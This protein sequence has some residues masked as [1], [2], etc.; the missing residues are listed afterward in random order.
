MLNYIYVLLTKIQVNNLYLESILIFFSVSP[1]HHIYKCYFSFLMEL[2]FCPQLTIQIFTFECQ[3]RK[4]LSVILLFIWLCIYIFMYVYIVP[5]TYFCTLST[6]L[7]LLCLLVS[8]V[9][10]NLLMSFMTYVVLRVYIN[11]DTENE[12]KY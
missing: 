12:G 9:S 2:F 8:R 7:S 10:S 11:L 3:D 6:P 4:W 5:W 1:S